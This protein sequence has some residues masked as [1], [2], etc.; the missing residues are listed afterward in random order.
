MAMLNKVMQLLRRLSPL[1]PWRL[2]RTLDKEFPTHSPFWVPDEDIDDR[3]SLTRRPAGSVER[4]DPTGMRPARVVESF[5]TL[6]DAV[7]HP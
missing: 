1:A 5:R 6:T 3:S 7:R 2:L 4:L